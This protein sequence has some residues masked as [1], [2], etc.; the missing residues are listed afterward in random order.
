M[1]LEEAVA[2]AGTFGQAAIVWFDGT[3][4]RL[5]WVPEAIRR[6]AP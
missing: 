1:A 6:S 4:A 5:V 3:V 2:A